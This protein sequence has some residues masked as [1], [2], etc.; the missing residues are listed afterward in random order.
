MYLRG[1]NEKIH[2]MSE[3]G[4]CTAGALSSCSSVHEAG[5]D[6]VCEFQRGPGGW[7]TPH[8]CTFVPRALFTQ[9]R[10]WA[11]S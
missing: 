8:P 9:D 5:P 3:E 1:V 10:G 11:Q 7:E 6:F 2:V 4:T